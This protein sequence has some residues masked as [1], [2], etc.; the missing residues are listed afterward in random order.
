MF[1]QHT[2]LLAETNGEGHKKSKI[3]LIS[4]PKKDPGPKKGEKNSMCFILSFN[5]HNLFSHH[6][7]FRKATGSEF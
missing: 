4:G 6:S 1:I 7:D 2:P 5:F 3:G